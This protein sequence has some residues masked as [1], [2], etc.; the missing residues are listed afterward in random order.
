MKKINLIFLFVASFCFLSCTKDKVPSQIDQDLFM[1]AQNSADFA[2][3][4]FNDSLYE[5][6]SGSGHSWP[7]LKTRYNGI[8]QTQ[9]D[10]EGKVLP[11]A[12]FPENSLIV[13]ELFADSTTIGRY[14]VMWKQSNH[15]YADE[16]GW[17]WGYI[18]A[19][20]T[21][22]T[23]ATHKGNTCINCHSQNENIDYTL[24]NKFFP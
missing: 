18:N 12:A 23:S 14:A 21:T 5:R 10:G 4:Q 22:A 13:K 20:G 3:Y 1:M 11:N 2:W 15:L 24:M 19:D 7:F 16:N 9:L 6:S 17:V 8:A